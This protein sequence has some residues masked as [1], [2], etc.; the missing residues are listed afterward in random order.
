M[1][2]EERERV[3]VVVE[4]DVSVEDVR[5]WLRRL[6]R[7]RRERSERVKGRR[8]RDGIVGIAVFFGFRFLVFWRERSGLI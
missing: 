1:V 3:D 2:D 7:R 5:G 6:L 8:R 4:V